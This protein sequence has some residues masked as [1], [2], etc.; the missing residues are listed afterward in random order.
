[1]LKK[2]TLREIRTSLARYLA[3]FAIVAL[4]VGFFSG[5]KDCKASMVSTASRYLDE[6]N[7]YDYMLISSYGIDDEINAD[8]LWAVADYASGQKTDEIPFLQNLKAGI[9]SYLY[10]LRHIAFQKSYEYPMTDSPWNIVALALYLM[11]IVIYCLQGEKH[12]QHESQPEPGDGGEH[13]G[14]HHE[15]MVQGGILPHRRENAQ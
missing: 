13:K 14:H 12:Q 3:I 9:V 4:G 1:M 6:H 7:M 10:R 2:S 15:D 5:L 11:A 8:T